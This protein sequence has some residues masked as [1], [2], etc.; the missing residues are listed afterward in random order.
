MILL[1]NVFRTSK[2]FPTFD[3]DRLGDVAARSAYTQLCGRRIEQ[4]Y[5]RRYH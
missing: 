3:Q 1:V 5:E 4:A 2:R